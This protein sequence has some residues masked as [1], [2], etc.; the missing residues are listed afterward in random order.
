MM[1]ASKR[2]TA[3]VLLAACGVAVGMCFPAVTSGQGKAAAKKPAA[4]TNPFRNRVDLPELPQGM[5]WYNTK[6]SISKADL[7]GKFV[8][9]DFWTYCCINCMHILP[10]LKKLEQR[11]PNQLVVIGIHSAKFE[12]ERDRENI[13]QAM[14]RYEVEHL[15]LNDD[16]HHLWDF[17]GINVWPTMLLVDPE[18]KV[19]SRSTGEFKAD[20]VAKILERGIPYYRQRNLLNEK[21]FP[22]D[23]VKAANTPLL[24]PGKVL[25]DEPGNRLF[26]SDSNHN[27]IVVTTLDGKL[28]DTIGSGAIGR[29]DG[30]FASA[31]FDHPQGCALHQ[32]MLYVA[33]TE[34]HLLRKVDLKARTVQSIAGTGRQADPLQPRVKSGT[35]KGTLLSSPWDLWIHKKSLFIAMAGSHQIWKMPLSESEIGPY[36][37]NGR[38]DIVDGRLLPK[39]AGQQSYSSFAQPSGLASDGE[40]LFVADSE[41]SSIRAV[42][43]EGSRE[44]V[45]VV[46]TAHR[47]EGRLFDFGDVDGP[48]TLAKFQ[49][50]IGVTFA[51]GALFVADTYNN[52]IR[53]VNPRT[54]E[55]TTLAGKGFKQAG[56]DDAEGTFDEPAGITHAKG[57]L[58]IADTN[59]HLIRTIDLAS[60]KVGT[61]TI[62]G[63]A[64]PNPPKVE[65]KPDFRGAAQ[66]KRE[67]TIAKA[68]QNGLT[69]HVTLKP[70]AGMEMS[71]EAPMVYWLDSPQESGPLDRAAF[72][73][74]NLEKPWAEF[75]VN[76]PVKG[77]GQDVLAVS[78]N[79][80]YCEHGDDGVCKTGSVIFTVPLNIT[81]SGSTK[82]IELTHTITD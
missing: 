64:A 21:P 36:A 16:K 40:W 43:L 68:A 10:E 4:T 53:E 50:C 27:R 17:Y 28:L 48:R 9:F 66:R 54:G 80:Y 20:D 6:K 78:L 60:G 51:D 44:V 56:D 33:D 38:E 65:T 46:G 52:K 2:C 5:E 77:T 75:D 63:L 15:V 58:Y 72:G 32:E 67:L 39:T 3:A 47:A 57:T 19:V 76:V 62:A 71:S 31:S 69:L 41:G 12:T 59:N 37:G 79:Y 26:I 45:T 8:L 13:I 55:T 11:Y 30:D 7:K 70:P 74:R 1:S 61:L 81:T 82:P 73:K 23:L 24:F 14:L 29:D 18:G 49:H 22:I 34:N 42:P 35:P 25:A